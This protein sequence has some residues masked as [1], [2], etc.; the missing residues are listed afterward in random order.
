MKVSNFEKTLSNFNEPQMFS[1]ISQKF[2]K[3]D[4]FSNFEKSCMF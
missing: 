4:K 2:D 1:K 3:F